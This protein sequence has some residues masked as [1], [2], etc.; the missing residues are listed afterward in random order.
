MKPLGG[1]TQ[2]KLN[3]IWDSF[4]TDKPYPTARIIVDDDTEQVM[5][6]NEGANQVSVSRKPGEEWEEWHDTRSVTEDSDFV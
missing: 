2:D 3:E 5:T 6:I 4:G 1:F